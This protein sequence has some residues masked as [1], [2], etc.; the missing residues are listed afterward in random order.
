MRPLRGQC[1]LYEHAS[2]LG[3]LALLL[4]TLRLQLS[5]ARAQCPDVD[6]LPLQR[7]PQSLDLRDVTSLNNNI[8]HVTS[9]RIAGCYTCDLQ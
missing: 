7:L 8:A 1:G 9:A 6:F 2:L 3:M 4:P 5:D